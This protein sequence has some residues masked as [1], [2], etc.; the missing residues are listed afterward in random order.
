M[1]ETTS[2]KI[3]AGMARFDSKANKATA[4]IA[5]N[6]ASIERNALTLRTRSA[7]NARIAGRALIKVKIKM[8]TA[9][10]NHVLDRLNARLMARP[11]SRP[12]TVQSA[13]SNRLVRCSVTNAA[14]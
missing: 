11:I 2:A 4:T 13:I 6:S 9:S 12:S 1:I 5:A 10:N 14:K 7:A 8:G 3:T